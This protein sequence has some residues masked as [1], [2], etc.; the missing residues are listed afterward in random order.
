MNKI[1]FVSFMVF[2]QCASGQGWKYH[3]IDNSS[4]GADGVKLSDI[5]NDGLLDITTG[6]EEGGLTKLYLHP[7]VDK[8]NDNWP[9]VIVGNTPNVEDAVF[10]DMNNNGLLDIVS[11]TEGNS[12]KIFVHW[13]PV[14]GL[15]E[16]ANWKQEVLP[17]SD[18][19]MMWMYAEPI[20]LDGRNGVDLLA[21]GKGS[22]AFLG[23]FE[24]PIKADDLYSWEWHP[25]SSVGWVMS[26]LKRDM[27]FDGDLDVVISD[28]RGALQGCRWLENPGIGKRQ[29]QP[30]KNH[31]IGGQNL[32]VM[33][34]CM[35]DLDGD[36]IEEVIV[37]ERSEQSLII[38][39]RMD[40]QG[41][42][43]KEK[44]I[45]LPAITGMAKSVEVGDINGDG[46]HD[47][48]IST[49]TNGLN[50]YGIVWLDGRIKDAPKESDWKI[51]SE[52]HP[53]KYDKVEL[54]DLDGDGDL[55]LLICEENFGKKS[56][57]LGVVWY[58]NPLK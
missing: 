58:E 37:C 32:E 41:I 51:I 12:K 1:F 28:R 25:I 19:R 10:I 6:W 55:D 8:V 18:G 30:W 14:K 33:F 45:R 21:A 11:C 9:S 31:F 46:I 24:A 17:A 4:S 36:G 13:A 48:V 34:M 29:K 43:W 52:A 56:E 2:I 27:D 39:Q 16:V 7:G 47:F 38:Y 23:W 57:G 3:I 53:A 5:N 35:A 15:L 50:K 54:I 20:Q 44:S 42:S 40:K 49:N 26:I 22:E